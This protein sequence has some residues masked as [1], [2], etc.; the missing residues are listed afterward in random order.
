MRWCQSCRVSVSASSAAGVRRT[1]S[2]Y[3]SGQLKNVGQGIL[4]VEVRRGASAWVAASLCVMLAATLTACGGESTASVT[5]EPTPSATSTP[6]PSGSGEEDSENPSSTPRERVGYFSD[7]TNTGLDNGYSGDDPIGINDPHYGWEL[8]RFVVS[9]YSST[10]KADG[11]DVFLKNVGDTVRLSFKLD[12]D[13]E[14]LNGVDGLAISEDSNG[15]DQRF[16]TEKTNFGRGALLVKYT[17][18]RNLDGQP[19]IYTD[20]LTGKLQGA[21]TEIQLLEEGDYEVALDYEVESPGLV[22]FT[23]S[24]NN[25]RISFRFA[26]RNGNAMVF[27]FDV[28]TG[29]ELPGDSITESGF[30]LDLAMSRY[31]NVGVT[32]EVLPEGADRLAD[33]VRFNRPAKDGETFTDEGLY[34][35][36]VV[37]QYTKAATSKRICVGTN[38]VLNAHV[39]TGLS[40]KEINELVAQ[41]AYL[42]IEGFIIL[43]S[44]EPSEGQ[45][46]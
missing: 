5:A 42:T 46:P 31:L 9:G 33:D 23:K 27:P 30:R 44:P 26:V 29:S 2:R 38:R 28:V 34:T 16:Q 35:I 14:R 15:Y 24:Y 43:P 13:I 11:T 6:E 40:V 1:S 20:Y 4:M 18:Y 32:K 41:G 25:Y 37:N 36:T 8:G 45:S 21:D 17:D 7:V 22:P 3:S 39:R 10:V 19:T 12:Q